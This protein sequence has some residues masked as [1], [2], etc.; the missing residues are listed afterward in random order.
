MK[1]TKILDTTIICLL[2]SICSLI[3]AYPLT[4]SAAP[5]ISL[6]KVSALNPQTTESTQSFS[7]RD[8]NQESILALDW[9][10]TSAE[11]RASAYQSYSFARLILDR[12]LAISIDHPAIVL[13][14]DETVF[15]NSPYY[16]AMVG[17]ELKNTTQSWNQWV[18]AK[19]AKAVPGAIEFIN[20]VNRATN[21][22]LFFI[23]N[24]YEKYPCQRNSQDLEI[25]TIDNLKQLGVA[26]VTDEN[27]ILRC[28]FANGDN[29]SKQLRIDA[30]IDGRAD[31]EKHNVILAIGDNLLDF[32][33]DVDLTLEARKEF[34]DNNASRFGQLNSNQDLRSLLPIFIILP[35]PIYGSWESALYQAKEFERNNSDELTTIQK[36]LQRLNALSIE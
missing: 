12:L 14:L 1:I 3:L 28:E 22:K 13:D 16:A 35:N 11:Y 33:E 18:K 17:T 20:Y 15:D 21:V 7:Q 4:A 19:K 27:V 32:A 29:L 26:N 5:N 9:V 24:R 25:A 34:V 23:S 36:N 30:V 6:E 2:F 8:L 31:G 10:Q